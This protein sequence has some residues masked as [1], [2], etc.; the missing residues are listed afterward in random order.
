MTDLDGASLDRILPSTPGPA[1]WDDVLRRSG[2]HRARRRRRLV[3]LAAVAVVAAGAASA[4]GMYAFVLDKGFIGLPPVGATASTPESGELVISYV[5]PT[6]DVFKQ[7]KSGEVVT[8]GGTHFWV[9]AD[10][11]LIWMRPG[12]DLPEGANPLFTGYLE[13]RLTPEGVELMRSEIISTAI[14]RDDDLVV[15]AWTVTAEGD[16]WWWVIRVRNGDR[17]VQVT[18]AGDP[19]RLVARLTD[20]ASWLPASAWEDRTIRAYVSSRF[21]VCWGGGP[22]QPVEP[23]RILTVLPAPVE[24]LLRARGFDQ[25]GP[26]DASHETACSSVTTEDARTIDKALAAA[27][28]EREGGAYSLGYRVT[29]P[30]LPDEGPVRP[31]I[32]FEPYLPHGEVLTCPACG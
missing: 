25:Y 18:R 16:R 20:P 30:A 24:D 13:Q 10:G 31:H 4:F 9:Y 26:P 14:L 32:W 23:S 11:R 3:V 28:L 27:G 2:A 1:D 8:S 5:G 7:L 15:E 17:L 12:V 19:E 21:A 29:D 22:Q 6:L